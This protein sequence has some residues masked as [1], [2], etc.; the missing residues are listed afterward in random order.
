MVSEQMYVNNIL[1]S[2][3]H[4]LDIH[5]EEKKSTMRRRTV[6]LKSWYSKGWYIH[7]VHEIISKSINGFGHLTW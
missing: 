7:Y 6:P 3:Q 4:S 5:T 2:L 1:S